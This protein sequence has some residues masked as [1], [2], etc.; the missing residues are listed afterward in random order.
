MR[1]QCQLM[2]SRSLDRMTHIFIG[3]SIVSVARVELG[4]DV[5]PKVIVQRRVHGERVLRDRSE[6]MYDEEYFGVRMYE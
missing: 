2:L 4:T 3:R 5:V 1:Y 6:A